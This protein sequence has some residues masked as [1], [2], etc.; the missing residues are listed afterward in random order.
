LIAGKY[1]Q[2]ASTC[3]PPVATEAPSMGLTR[4]Q[5]CVPAVSWLKRSSEGTIPRESGSAPE[6][7]LHPSGVH[8]VTVVFFSQTEADQS[9]D[10]EA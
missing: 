8:P 7:L 1:V 2:S 5:Y 3:G 4:T 6:A 9:H 10:P